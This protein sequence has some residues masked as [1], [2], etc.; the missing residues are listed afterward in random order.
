MMPADVLF[1][2]RRS[3]TSHWYFRNVSS[4]Y[5]NCFKS[6][7]SAFLPSPPLSKGMS[8]RS[9]ALNLSLPF[10]VAKLAI[11]RV[12]VRYV[13]T[14]VSFSR[15]SIFSI[16]S[17]LSIFSVLVKSAVLD[18]CNCGT[19]DANHGLRAKDYRLAVMGKKVASESG[20]QLVKKRSHNERKWS[21]V[22]YWTMLL[23]KPTR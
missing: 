14:A 18:C 22:I 23:S 1:V 3:R 20:W 13:L 5:W 21:S 12:L 11:M 10:P 6:N 4:A 7:I 15:S 16:P 19:S 8:D 9:F 2:A 17:S